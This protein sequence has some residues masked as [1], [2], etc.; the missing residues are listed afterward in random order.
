[1]LLRA[2]SL[3]LNFTKQIQIKKS[4]R[5]FATRSSRHYILREK[6]DEDDYTGMK[7]QRNIK[8]KKEVEVEEEEGHSSI[9]LHKSRG[10]H[11][12]TNPRVLDAI[13]KKADIRPTDTVLEIGPGTGNLTLRLLDVAQKVIA[14][15]IDKRMIEILNNRV[16]QR[17]FEDKITVCSK[18]INVYLYAYML[19]EEIP[20]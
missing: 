6:N 19:F 15:E 16:S 10:Q 12:L 1:M 13:V 11:I 8:G 14:V 9:Y 5:F 7:K 4:L 17:G 2:K 18:R 20:H 3:S